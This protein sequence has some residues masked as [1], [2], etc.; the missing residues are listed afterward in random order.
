MDSRL[1]NPKTASHRGPFSGNGGLL[2]YDLR[3]A[4]GDDQSIAE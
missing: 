1:A 3:I 2:E 4:S